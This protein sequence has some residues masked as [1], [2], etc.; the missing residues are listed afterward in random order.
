[1]RTP[2][3][4]LP[5]RACAAIALAACTGRAPALAPGAE[6]A[7]VYFAATTT[8]DIAYAATIDTDGRLTLAGMAQASAFAALARVDAD[9]FP[10]GTFGSGGLLTSTMASG[11]SVGL[12]AL[13]RMADG[14]LVAC[15]QTFQSG[16]ATDFLVA[17]FL[18]DGSPDTS[19]N[20][21]GHVA[22]AFAGTSGAALFDRCLAVAVRPD[23]RILAAGSTAQNGGANNVALVRYMPDGTLDAT[24]GNAGR[25]IVNAAA[26]G[27]SS[28]NEARAIALQ[29]DG[30][31]VIAGV[32]FGSGANPDLLVMR[33]DADGAADPSF[34]GTGRVLTN[35]GSDDAA[36]ALA[37]QSDGRIVIAGQA[38]TVASG[39]RDFVVARYAANGVL[40]A[41][42]GNGGVL[43][44]A[45]GL[46]DDVAYALAVMP[47]G[48]IVVAGSSRI[49]AS[50]PGIEL[51]VAALDPDGTFDDYFSDNGLVSVS[52]G[53]RTAIGY[54]VVADFVHP[55]LW[56]VGSGDRGPDGED[57]MAVEFGLPD[58]LLRDGFDIHTN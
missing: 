28:D 22:T 46:S 7:R 25:V 24:F 26:S 35:I 33:F 56:V 1:M 17:R 41:S 44:I 21:S 42:F 4:S 16:S 11:G 51:V 15:G 57:L 23:G 55:R 32:A 40:D 30:R 19:F 12:R 8:A 2:T 18:A 34:A 3:H 54:A 13:A 5:L 45:Y 6:G 47:W 29:P 38:R 52:L 48:R 14:R 43:T 39:N 20:G 49:S 36:N 9:G 27:S 31:I 10:D 58:T 50:T 37:L 53:D